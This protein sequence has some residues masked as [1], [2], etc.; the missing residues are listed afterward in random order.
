VRKPDR[1]AEIE[2]VQVCMGRHYE[3]QLV[4]VAHGRFLRAF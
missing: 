4:D 3:I 1:Q 2:H